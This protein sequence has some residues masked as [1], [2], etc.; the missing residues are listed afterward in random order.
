MQSAGASFQSKTNA[1]VKTTDE[2]EEDR[3][4]KGGECFPPEV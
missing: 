4:V 3:K 2:H 1:K